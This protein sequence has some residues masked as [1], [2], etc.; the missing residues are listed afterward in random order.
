MA[1]YP[2]CFTLG[3]GSALGEGGGQHFS[4][5]L[6]MTVPVTVAISGSNAPC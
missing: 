1:H 6:H 2:N 4:Q 5:V 3:I